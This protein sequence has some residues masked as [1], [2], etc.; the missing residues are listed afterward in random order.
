MGK[1]SIWDGKQL[2]EVGDDVLIHLSSVNSWETYTVEGFH[3]WPSLHGDK[4]HHRIFVDVFRM[5]S[6]NK[7]K[8][9]RL[10]CDIRPVFWKEPDHYDPVGGSK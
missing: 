4:S 7:I 5:E 1:K 2:P 10:L 3:I 6:S 8:N 9:S